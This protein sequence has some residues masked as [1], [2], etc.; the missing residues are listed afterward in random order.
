[1]AQKKA[2]ADITGPRYRKAGKTKK[3]SILDE[4]CQSTG[5]NRKY[6]ITLLHHAG[7]TQLRRM[8]SKTVKVKISARGR[9]KR[10]YKRIYDEPVEKAVL[11]IWDFFHQVCGKRLVPM[12]RANL[13]AL[14]TEFD[15]PRE[16]QEKLAQVSS[17]TVE[18]M[19]GQERK[20][21]KTRGTCS[22]KPGTLLKHQIPVRT[23][24]H[25]EDKKVGFCEIDTV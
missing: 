1:M 5:Y 15:I 10:L 17:S 23:F 3:S 20:R 7:K 4:F 21:H 18:R 8:G 6:A 24:W 19:L 25:W 2:L 16:V 9:R 22:I 13:K 12:I 11:A 14:A